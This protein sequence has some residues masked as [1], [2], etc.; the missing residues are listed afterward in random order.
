[1]IQRLITTLKRTAAAI[2]VVSVMVFGAVLVTQPAMAAPVDVLE[3]CNSQSK[4]CQGTNSNSLYN[5]IKNVINVL[6]FI[7]GIIAVI[8]IIIGGFRYT[9]SGGDGSETKTARDTIIYAVAGLVI[10]IMSFAIVNFVLNR[11][12]S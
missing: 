10:A 2:S 12:Q 1:M 8:M 5:I 3:E 6:L 4:V 9:T 7:I 11:L